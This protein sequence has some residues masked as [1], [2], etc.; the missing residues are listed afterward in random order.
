MPAKEKTIMV[1]DDDRDIVRICQLGLEKAGFKVHAFSDS[2]LALQHVKQG[3]KG[4]QVMVSDVRMP[5]MNG[6]QLVEKIRQVRPEMK[7]VMM[8]AFEINKSEFESL[9]PSTHIDSVLKKPFSPLKLVT[10]IEKVSVSETA[11]G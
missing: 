10:T 9:F 8:T 6:F 4:C 1:V 11:T 5:H 7:L 3:C 2:V